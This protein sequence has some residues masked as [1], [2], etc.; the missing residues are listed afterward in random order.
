MGT[1]QLT[2]K[3]ETE[4]TT[5][6][7]MNRNGYQAPVTQWEG[8]FLQEVG[9]VKLTA[10]GRYTGGQSYKVAGVLGNLARPKRYRGA[11]IYSCIQYV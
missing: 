9:S 11:S 8:G 3:T 2:R 6:G 7:Q 1:S 10:E 4:P 5:V